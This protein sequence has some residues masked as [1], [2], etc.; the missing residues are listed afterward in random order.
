MATFNNPEY[1]EAS[2]LLIGVYLFFFLLYVMSNSE[3]DLYK[4]LKLCVNIVTSIILI[5]T[6][7]FIGS[8]YSEA[9]KARKLQR[10]DI[11]LK[12]TPYLDFVGSYYYFNTEK[13]ALR[14]GARLVCVG[15]TPAHD[16]QR[17]RDIVFYVNTET[18]AK[19]YEGKNEFKFNLYVKN[20]V[21]HIAKYLRNNPDVNKPDVEEFLSTLEND[22]PV[23][24]ISDSGGFDLKLRIDGHNVIGPAFE[25]FG[26]PFFVGPGRTYISEIGRSFVNAPF[27]AKVE[28]KHVLLMYYSSW[29]WEGLDPGNKMFLSFLGC[30]NGIKKIIPKEDPKNKKKL[31]INGFSKM[32]IWS[33]RI[34]LPTDY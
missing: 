29:K 2:F 7:I 11:E 15:T 3:L 28:K 9:L 26:L 22:P 5:G 8:Q 27:V 6:M 33:S 24:H 31:D 13:N 19:L 12:N 1:V 30:T 20:L 18:T 16:V 4:K 32:T 17:H 25:Y 21:D 14:L 10:K 23:I 34:E